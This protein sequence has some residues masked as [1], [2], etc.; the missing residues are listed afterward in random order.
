MSL[1][2][3]FEGAVN[4]LMLGGLYVVVALGLSMVFGVMRLINVTHGELLIVAAYLNYEVSRGLGIDPVFA[5]IMIIPV[6]FVIG[7]SIQLMI[8]NPVMNR[9]MEPPLLMA[10]GLSIIA[11]NAMLLIWGGD[12]R[13]LSASY[14]TEGFSLLGVNIP[15]MY[16]IAF[17]MSLAVIGVTHLYIN[18][19]YLGKAIRA[20]TQDPH[21]AGVLGV[22][23]NQI[24]AVTY[25]LGASLASLGG[26][27]IGLT[28]SFAPAGGFPWLLKSFVVVIL[29]GMGSISGTLAGGLLLGVAEGAGAP[30]VGSGYRDM[31]GYIIFLAVLLLRPRGLFG[32]V[33][34]E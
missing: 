29:G 31:I 15:L 32:R 24:Y 8:L 30:I 2:L 25:A 13:G 6:L 19:T 34:S 4:G 21:T 5:A 12:T 16:G 23:V 27:L 1:S 22:N 9:G 18:N 14:N 20:A 7:Y 17:V 28:F 26:L 10:F 11:Q 33:G 3:V